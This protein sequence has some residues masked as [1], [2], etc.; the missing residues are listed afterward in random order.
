MDWHFVNAVT[1]ETATHRIRRIHT[2][3]STYWLAERKPTNGEHVEQLP[4]RFPL[5]ELAEAACERD[6]YAVASGR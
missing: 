5:M 6:S 3:R 4:G 2:L 1:Y